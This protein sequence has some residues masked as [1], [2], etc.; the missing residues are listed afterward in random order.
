MNVDTLLAEGQLAQ[1]HGRYGAAEQ[2]SQAAARLSAETPLQVP[3]QL[4]LANLLRLQGRYPQ[5]EALLLATLELAERTVGPRGTEVA[6]ICNVLGMT[7]KY[8]GRFDE[9]EAWYRR[10]L[11]ILGPDH[12]D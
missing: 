2:A 10:A 1:D 7:G 8:T 5:A 9:A 4:A 6:G 3:A 11:D 12:P